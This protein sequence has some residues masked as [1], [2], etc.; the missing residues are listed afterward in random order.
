ME[1]VGWKGNSDSWEKLFTWTV[2]S[3]L[4]DGSDQDYDYGLG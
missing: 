3:G 2:T 1:T 4:A